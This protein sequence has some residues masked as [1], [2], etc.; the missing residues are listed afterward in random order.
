MRGRIR[1]ARIIYALQ[2]AADRRV[3]RVLCC[4][5][6]GRADS[7]QRKKLRRGLA[8]HSNATVCA[9][10]GMDKALMKSV[11]R[12]ELAPVTHRIADVMTA[13]MAGFGCHD[14]VSLHA[15]AVRAGAFML[16]L[17]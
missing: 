1:H 4:D 16:D 3:F 6:Y 7:H 12:R 9:R 13:G 5:I 15:E 8:M 11:T 14:G 10:C 2:G 17:A